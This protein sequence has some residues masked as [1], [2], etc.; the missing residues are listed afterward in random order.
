[1]T[2][3]SKYKLGTIKSPI[4]E[5]DLRVSAL[6]LKEVVLPIKTNNKT[7][8]PPFRDQ[9]SQPTCAAMTAALFKYW[10]ENK[11]VGLTEVLSP[12]FVYNLREDKNSEGMTNRDLHKILQ[13]K[14]ICLES[15]Y[16]YGWSKLPSEAAFTN[17]LLYRI[18]N[19][20]QVDT[21]QGLKMMLYLN[22]PCTMAVPVY[23][24]GERMWFQ[25]PGEEL[26]GGHDLCIFDYDDE[27]QK[28]RYRNH[29]AGFG[30]ADGEAEMD[31][32]DFEMIWEFW[33]SVDL[34]TIVDRPPIP[35]PEPKKRTILDWLK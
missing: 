34:A 3:F 27:K 21:L 13:S 8:M 18:K 17:A 12:Q 5:R 28:F 4:D 19:Y 24:Y 22:G 6:R 31:Y 30:D 10:Q 9:G 14:G 11:D 25:N 16:R 29:W 35:D 2:D 20:V 23:N 26:L 7:T 32:S 1:M 15:L 33:T